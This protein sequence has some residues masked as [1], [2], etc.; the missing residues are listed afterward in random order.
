[1]TT[2]FIYPNHSPIALGSL[3]RTIWGWGGAEKGTIYSE[4]RQEGAVGEGSVWVGWRAQKRCAEIC[5]RFGHRRPGRLEG[6]LEIV[7]ETAYRL[8]VT[9]IQR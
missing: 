4:T 8:C 9:M 3:R 7:M 6:F 5:G 2:P 1:L